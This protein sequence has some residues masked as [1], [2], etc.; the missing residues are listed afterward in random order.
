MKTARFDFLRLAAGLLTSTLFTLLALQASAQVASA[1]HSPKPLYDSA[2]EITLSGT[3][4]S[5][6]TKYV[7]GSP[8]GLHVRVTG[9]QG[10]I[11]V[12]LGPYLSKQTKEALHAG[13]PV[14]IVGAME[15]AHGQ[16]WLLARLLML[17]GQ[18]ITVRSA[19]GFLVQGQ[20]PKAANV[21][22]GG[23]VR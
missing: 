21:T 17:S 19:N 9:S 1:S 3:V 12:H 8:A 23:G 4:Q 11:D 14:Q 7:P 10:V 6:V 5:V 2:H 20:T 22:V 16:Q 15:S 18:T 13:A